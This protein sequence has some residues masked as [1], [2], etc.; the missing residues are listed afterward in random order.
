MFTDDGIVCQHARDARPV[1]S[2]VYVLGRG[3]VKGIQWLT[4]ASR[5]GE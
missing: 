3:R 2:Y 1:D 5:G 4:E